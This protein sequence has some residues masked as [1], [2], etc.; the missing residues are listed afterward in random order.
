MGMEELLKLRLE[1]RDLLSHEVGDGST[2]SLW[3]D[4]WHPNGV[5][6]QTY[7]HRIVHD[8]ASNLQAKVSSV[9]QNKEWCWCPAR[10]EDMAEIQSKLS[11]I[12]IK[13]S[14]KAVWSL[15]TAG[16]FNCAATWKHLRSKQIEVPWWKLIWFQGAIPKH[17]FIGWLAMKDRLTTKDRLLL[18]GIN[19]DLVCQ[20]CRQ[21]MEDRN[22]LFFKC[23]FS[24]RIWKY[25]MGL[26]LASSAPDNWDL[27]L[28][29]G[30][31]NL[32]GRSFRVTLC[33]IAWWATLYHLWQ[34]RNARLHAGEMKSEEN[35]IKAIRRDV[36]AKMEPVKSPTSILHQTLCNNW[37]ILLCTF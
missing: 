20:F 18:W 15:T 8:A 31:K 36:K 6:Y 35:I 32:K 25:I 2:I 33:K 11:L 17:C 9:I 1:A 7:G 23:S 34:Q 19:V 5:L 27:L 12:Q 22:H 26:C 14:D 28:E 16:N 10:L 29:C 4:R 24:S 3:H 21:Y 13:E 37:N 30:I